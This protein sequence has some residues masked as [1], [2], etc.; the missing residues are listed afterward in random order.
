MLA[1]LPMLS[2]LLGLLPAARLDFS[3]LAGVAAV[4]DG[5]A[6]LNGYF[7]IATLGLCLALVFGLKIFMLGYR[8]LLFVYHQ[9]WGSS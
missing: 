3:A 8:V 5:A 1:L 4:G 9:F 2:G 6:M 7:P